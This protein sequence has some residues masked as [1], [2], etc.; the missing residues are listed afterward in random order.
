MASQPPIVLFDGDCTYCNGWVNWIR[1]RDPAGRFRFE[2]LGSAQGMLLRAQFG[3]PASTDSVVLIQ[4]DTAH[5]RSDAAWRILRLLPGH[6]AAAV[7]LRSVPGPLRNWG[8]DL[9]ARNR[10]RLGIADSCEL[11]PP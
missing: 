6:R 7:L 4:D 9:V 8:Y 3:L 1:K 10:H 2:A 5:V 11:P